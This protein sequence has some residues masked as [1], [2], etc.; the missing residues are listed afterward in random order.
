MLSLLYELYPVMGTTALF[1][2]CATSAAAFFRQQRKA[3]APLF[4]LVKKAAALPRSILS[5]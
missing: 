4:F 3:A 5:K 1:T 2:S